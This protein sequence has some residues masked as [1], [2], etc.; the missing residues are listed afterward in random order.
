MEENVE[1][2]QI[3]TEKNR[4]ASWEENSFGPLAFTLAPG[5]K[6]KAYKYSVSFLAKFS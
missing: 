2:T 3:V 6:Y 4:A 1:M 5:L